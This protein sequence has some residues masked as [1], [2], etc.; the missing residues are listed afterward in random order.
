VCRQQRAQHAHMIGGADLMD[1]VDVAH[2]DLPTD[3]IPIGPR[4][5]ELGGFGT[6]VG[7][8]LRYSNAADA[9]LLKRQDKIAWRDF[10][11]EFVEGV[12]RAIGLALGRPDV[13]AG[14]LLAP[15]LILI[16]PPVGMGQV[17]G[18]C[19]RGGTRMILARCAGVQIYGQSLYSIASMPLA[20]LLPP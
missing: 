6:F 2:V 11:H 1:R 10:A 15:S 16:Y 12:A 20:S 14:P 13:S 4:R 17:R 8:G 3:I 18:R 7:V 5:T 9:C 19:R